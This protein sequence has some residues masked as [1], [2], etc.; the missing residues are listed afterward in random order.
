MS[1]SCVAAVLAEPAASTAAPAATSTVTAP[2]PDGVNPTDALNEVAEVTTTH[3]ALEQSD[4]SVTRYFVT[5][6]ASVAASPS[7][8][9][10]DVVVAA[11]PLIESEPVGA[12]VSPGPEGAA[13]VVTV[14]A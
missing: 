5:P 14:K 12:V 9:D 6:T 8:T 3:E 10:V 1:A 11:P 4:P 7:V 13:A 2:W